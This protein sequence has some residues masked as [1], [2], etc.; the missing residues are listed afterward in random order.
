MVDIK[1]KNA[2]DAKASARLFDDEIGHFDPTREGSAQFCQ[3]VVEIASFAGSK[4]R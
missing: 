3:I 1:E 2:G 4:L